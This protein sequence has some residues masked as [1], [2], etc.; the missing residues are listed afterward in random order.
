MTHPSGDTPAAALAREQQALVRA[1][2]A[3]GPT[4]PGF[5]ASALADTAHALLH[6]RAAEVAHRFPRLAHACG[7]DF[8]SRYLAW[9]RARPKTTTAA[10]AAAFAA[11]TGLPVPQR[12]SLHR[13]LLRR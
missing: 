4:P 13:R 2:V 11:A 6:K 10:D 12:K 7:P 3:G 8:T 9:A 5:D 1:L